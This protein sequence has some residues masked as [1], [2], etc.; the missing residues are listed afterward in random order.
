MTGNTR[1][2]WSG[3]HPGAPQR[4]GEPST[5]ADPV[6]RRALDLALARRCV[7]GDRDA[8]LALFRRE[9]D[10]VHRVLRRIL[11]GGADVEDAA[12]D[13]FLALYRSLSGYRGEALLATWID[14]ITVRT[15]IAFLR[16][17]TPVA[18]GDADAAETLADPGPRPDDRLADHELSQRLYAALGRLDPRQ[19]VAFVLHVI[20]DHSMA[21]VA[22]L[23]G[24]TRVATKT[25]VWRA[26][27][28]LE[29]RAARDPVL[30]ALLAAKGGTR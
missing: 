21:E 17:R 15:A 8:Q 19:R 26:Q 24:A 9:V 23:M 14:R 27:R 20:E 2:A 22:A 5:T 16:R 11:G 18:S 6:A 13:A 3:R 7:A 12:Q 29:R 25:R 30:A 4:E 10:R 28:A 1:P